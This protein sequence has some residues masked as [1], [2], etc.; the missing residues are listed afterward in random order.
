LPFFLFLANK[1]SERLLRAPDFNLSRKVF[2]FSLI[3]LFADD[4]ASSDEVFPTLELLAPSRTVTSRSTSKNLFLGGNTVG[5]KG[6]ALFFLAGV[7]VDGG[8]DVCDSVVVA[9][10]VVSCDGKIVVCG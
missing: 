2:L 1:L 7:V 6:S 3:T 5:A 8:K 9:S 10:G 4:A